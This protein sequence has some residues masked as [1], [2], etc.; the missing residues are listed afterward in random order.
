MGEWNLIRLAFEFVQ[1]SEIILTTRVRVRLRFDQMNDCLPQGDELGIVR[2]T[3]FYGDRLLTTNN[4]Q[5]DADQALLK[6]LGMSGITRDAQ[7]AR[8][9]VA[10]G[11]E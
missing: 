1:P 9:P 4:P 11:V 5:A 6:D 10:A 3:D 7:A 8:E 2:T